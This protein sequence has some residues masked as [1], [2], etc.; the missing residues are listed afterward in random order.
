MIKLKNISK[1]YGNHQIFDNFN[2]M[3]KEGEMLAIMGRSGAGKS[4][5]L[6][7]IGLVDLEYDG[8]LIIDEECNCK[9]RK[10]INTLRRNSIA[11][12]FQNFGLLENKTI[13]ENLKLPFT[14]SSIKDD[15][16]RNMMSF[17]LNQVGLDKD[18]NTMVYNLSGGEMQRVAIAKLLM[19]EP[20]IILA[21]EPTGSLDEQTEKQIMDILCGLNCCGVTV[22]I[23]THSK[24]VSKYCT[25]SIIIGDDNNEIC[26][27][28]N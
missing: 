19:K 16:L 25:R 9:N 8:T 26:N 17:S 20:K 27:N 2:L 10:T 1:S 22:V 23:V 5:L 14:F 18:L 7:I 13:Y 24:N 11:Y 6:N 28:D 3:I 12:L 4:T 15:E 21:D